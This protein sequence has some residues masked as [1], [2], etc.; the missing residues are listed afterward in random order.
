MIN[1]IGYSTISNGFVAN[2]S[3][4]PDR[5]TYQG[6]AHMAIRTADV[7]AFRT[8]NFHIMKKPIARRKTSHKENS[9]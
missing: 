5:C 9:L 6:D 7:E 8:V 4:V 2:E 1:V 3:L